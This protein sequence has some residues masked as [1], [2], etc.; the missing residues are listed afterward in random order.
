MTT[1]L[2]AI[3]AIFFLGQALKGLY[4]RVRVPEALVFIVL[5]YV[6]GPILGLF[7]EAEWNRFSLA[8]SELALGLVVYFAALSFGLRD[9][10]RTSLPALALLVLGFGTALCT[11][12]FLGS[13]FQPFSTAFYCGLGVA[14][15]GVG[16]VRSFL[17]GN[18]AG[19]GVE[20][21]WDNEALWAEG[22]AAALGLIC[23]AGYES[24]IF[25]PLLVAEAKGV[26]LGKSLAIGLG[27]GVIWSILDRRAP[28]LTR[29]RFAADA[30]WL[31]TFAA[32]GKAGFS[33]ALAGL[34]LGFL[35][36]QL[37]P[38][39]RWLGLIFSQAKVDEA[40][41]PA[42]VDTW[43]VVSHLFFLHL[44]TQLK[45]GNLNLV[46]FCAAT[47][48][49]T[50]VARFLWVFV[51]ASPKRFSRWEA[52]SLFASSP[53]GLCAL[54]LSAVPVAFP[55]SAAGWG[56]SATALVVF[57]SLVSSTVLLALTGIPGVRVRA[58]R[59]FGRYKEDFGVAGLKKT[60]DFAQSL[61]PVVH[62]AVA[63]AVPAASPVFPELSQAA[64]PA[65]DTAEEEDGS[66]EWKE[67]TLATEIDISSLE[68]DPDSKRKAG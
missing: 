6:A 64:P 33:G 11:G 59:L 62:L 23:L 30:W 4:A 37:A 17:S 58:H 3:A 15:L 26:W 34:A 44:G 5:G 28:S 42:L 38:G 21:I 25:D 35:Q 29:T 43:K 1:A 8:L 61:A 54:A 53:R 27:S 60:E 40:R 31:L 68:D 52:M 19:T 20:K 14:A 32:V 51:A 24:H 2:A 46:I 47:L 36:A 13:L 22:L 45:F 7:P 9:L 67:P 16:P 48:S 10:Y 12:T 57:F 39:P 50:S 18:R 63:E 65:S 49:V 55:N 56:A 41:V 66:G